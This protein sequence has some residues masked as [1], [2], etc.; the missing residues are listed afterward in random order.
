MKTPYYSFK[1]ASLP[2]IIAEYGIIAS[3]LRFLS[4]QNDKMRTATLTN[5]YFL[6]YSFGEIDTISL[7]TRLNVAIELNPASSDIIEISASV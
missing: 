6:R 7:K 4:T 1:N 3:S 5:A 2:I